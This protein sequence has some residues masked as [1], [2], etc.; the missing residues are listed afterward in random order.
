[1]SSYNYCLSFHFQAMASSS[2]TARPMVGA[3]SSSSAPNKE[4]LQ[5]SGRI[6]KAHLRGGLGLGLEKKPAGPRPPAVLTPE[7]IEK[8]MMGNTQSSMTIRTN[9]LQKVNN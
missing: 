7:H 3:T 1:M 4:N 8:G 6:N 2:T 9:G 5:G